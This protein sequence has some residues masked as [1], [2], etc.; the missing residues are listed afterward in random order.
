MFSFNILLCL[1]KQSRELIMVISL[2]MISKYSGK[3]HDQIE[4]RALSRFPRLY[5][6][7]WIKLNE[8]LL[9][10]TKMTTHG[11]TDKVDHYM[12]PVKACDCVYSATALQQL[13][14]R[15]RGYLAMPLPCL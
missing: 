11:Q 5:V 13:H 3:E 9:R 12:P 6:S 2:E 7:A 14:P 1:F 10:S 15:T 8:A 4:G